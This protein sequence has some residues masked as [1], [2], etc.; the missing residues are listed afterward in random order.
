MRLLTFPFNQRRVV[1]VPAFELLTRFD[2]GQRGRNSFRR[3]FRIPAPTSPAQ[4]RRELLLRQEHRHPVVNFRSEV[5]RLGNDHRAQLQPLAGVAVF[6]LV[7]KTGRYRSLS[8]RL[9]PSSRFVP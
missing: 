8:S 1:G 6:P 2:T 5:V 3:C 7:P 4:Q 9:V